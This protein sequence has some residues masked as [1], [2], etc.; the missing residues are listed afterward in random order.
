VVLRVGSPTPAEIPGVADLDWQGSDE[1]PCS[2]VGSTAVGQG[3]NDTAPIGRPRLPPAVPREA[4]Q[5]TLAVLGYITLI[6]LTKDF[7]TFTWGVFYFVVVLE[8]VPRFVRRVRGRGA[9]PPQPTL[10]ETTES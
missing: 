5:Y 3:S 8:V 2:G 4:L 9:E 6:L 1:R 7:L 10:S